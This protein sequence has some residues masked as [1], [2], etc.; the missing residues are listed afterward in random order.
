MAKYPF[1]PQAKQHIAKLELDY[2][3]LADLPR[4]RKRAK[5][6]MYASFELAMRLSLE[7]D[8][9]FE[10]EILSYP[11][12]ILYATG[13]GDRHLI[14]RYALFEA[15]QINRYLG[16]EKREDV[17]LEIAKAFGWKIQ[18]SEEK[19][20]AILIHFA[21]YLENVSKGRLF[22]DSKW[23][24]V[25]RALDKGW[26]RVNSQEVARLLQEEVKKRIEDSAQQELTK[27][28][29]DIQKDIAEIKAEFL[30]RRPQLEELDQLIHAQ[31]SEYPPCISDLMTRAAKGQ[32]L[33]HVERFTLVTYLLR[34]GISV[35]S[36]VS[37][38][39]NV[40][41]FKEDKTRYQVEHLAGERG[42]RTEPY[43]P[44]NCATLQTHGICKKPADPICYTIKN[45]L[46]YH[47]RKPRQNA[48]SA[49]KQAEPQPL[50]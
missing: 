9:D 1:L 19:P 46:T 14:E 44:Y 40:S 28:P 31:E 50:S 17:I 36:V 39:S 27:I 7:P 3:A 45:P 29:E 41:D 30:K 47:L 37:L 33:S 6:R 5:Q 42:G 21:K 20:R 4:I 12:A 16:E 49:Q 2:K 25:N 38:F 34:Q 26:V 23:K 10:T 8:S 13:T 43:M 15:V 35:D 24:L 32:H 48:A 18:I 22:H 11:L